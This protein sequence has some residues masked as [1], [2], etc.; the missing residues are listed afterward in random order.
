MAQEL[1]TPRAKVAAL[2]HALLHVSMNPR[3]PEAIQIF[4]DLF[5]QATQ[6]FAVDR[7]DD[8]PNACVL[9]NNQVGLV[10]CSGVHN[11]ATALKTAAGWSDPTKLTAAGG[12]NSA[13]MA[14]VTT[15]LAPI[16]LSQVRAGVETY[17]LGHSW[18]GMIVNALSWYLTTQGK[19]PADHLFTIG[20]PRALADGYDGSYATRNAVRFWHV[21]DPVPV[22]PPRF[23]EA[24]ELVCIAAGVQL[25]IAPSALYLIL[26]RPSPPAAFSLWPKFYQED[27]GLMLAANGLSIALAD[28]VPGPFYRRSFPGLAA[29]LSDAEETGSHNLATYCTSLDRWAAAELQALP[30]TP[31]PREMPGPPPVEL[32]VGLT[33][34]VDVNGDFTDPD[35]GEFPP[36]ASKSVD[37]SSMPSGDGPPVGVLFL[38][39]EQVATFPNRSKART[40]ARHLNRFLA[41][42]PGADEVSVSGMSAGILAYLNDASV[43]KGVDRK[44]VRLGS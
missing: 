4:A 11:F 39:G 17:F 44:P 5:G 32:V 31:A 16:F 10:L 7:N 21:D 38:R 25:P 35:E 1:T 6:V 12:F 22:L 29:A 20:A 2:M 36:M 28:P 37:T 40:A 42:L 34:P 19:P 8:R 33:L 15:T 18:G 43:G 13:A 23:D 30:S 41:K 24:P 27:G 26:G 9:S 14:V 3:A